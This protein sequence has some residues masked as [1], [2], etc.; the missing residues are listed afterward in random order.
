M[1]LMKRKQSIE[2]KEK[3]RIEKLEHQKIQK[4]KESSIK[5]LEIEKRVT[6]AKLNTEI[7]IKSQVD[8]FLEKERQAQIRRK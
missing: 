7:F 3:K 1:E 2:F 5:R 8:S 4:A 6:T